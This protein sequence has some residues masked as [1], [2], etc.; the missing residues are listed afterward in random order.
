MDTIDTIFLTGELITGKLCRCNEIMPVIIQQ[1]TEHCCENAKAITWFICGTIIQ[2]VLVIVVG[3]LL[4]KI[5]DILLKNNNAKNERKYKERENL[6]KL[7]QDYQARVLEEFVS[8]KKICEHVEDEKRK[9][10]K[11]EKEKN[12]KDIHDTKESHGVSEMIQQ[13]EKLLAESSEKA[14]ICDKIGK[15]IQEK[16]EEIQKHKDEENRLETIFERIEK[17]QS[18]I[19]NAKYIEKLNDYLG[20]IDGKISDLNNELGIKNREKNNLIE[21]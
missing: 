15:Y 2:V 21:N 7:K 5:I 10:E 13:I 6:I 18:V 8:F 19:A 17:D 16:K 3:W 20:K 11:I 9:L 1:T 4:C 14:S 12:G